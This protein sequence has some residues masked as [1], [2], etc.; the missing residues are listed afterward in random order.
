MGSEIGQL[1]RWMKLLRNKRP[2]VKKLAYFDFVLASVKVVN[3]VLCLIMKILF[4]LKRMQ[5]LLHMS[6]QSVARAYT[7]V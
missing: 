7:L 3:L 4:L 1:D 2:I 6:G 5:P